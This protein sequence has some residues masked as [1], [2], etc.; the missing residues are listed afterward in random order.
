MLGSDLVIGSVGREFWDG[1]AS[2]VETLKLAKSMG[3][4]GLKV[5]TKFCR[6]ILCSFFCCNLSE[7]LSFFHFSHSSADL[8]DFL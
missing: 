3:T 4:W 2:T 8:E 7:T 5:P 6:N 1:G